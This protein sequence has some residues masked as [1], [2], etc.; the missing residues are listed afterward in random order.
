MRQPRLQSLI[1]AYSRTNRIYGKNKE[2]GSI[3]N[4]QYPKITEERVN[5]ALKLYGSGGKSSRAIVDTYKTAVEKLSIKVIEMIEALED[6]TN[7]QEL[8]GDSEAEE[9][10]ILSFKDANNQLG[11]VMQY[12]EYD[13]DDS[14]FG[15]DEHTWMKYVGA[16][17][18]LTYT[19]VDPPEYEPVTP[20]VGKTKLSGTQVI[21]ADHILALIGSKVKTDKGVQTV[22]KETLRIIYEEIQELSNM[23][24]DEQAKLL[25]E[26]V[27]TELVPGHLSSDL[28]FDDSFDNWKIEKLD[29]EVEKFS[30]EWGI[31]KLILIKSLN[32]F[33]MRKKDFIPYI[34]ELQ[35]N[36]NFSIAENQVAGNQLKHM[37]TLINK[38]IPEWFVEMKQKYKQIIRDKFK[39]K[40]IKNKN[41]LV[42]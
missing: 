11:L 2:F 36:I 30:E 34:D 29:K 39:L 40:S 19:I 21:D 16:Y 18:N 27:E 1:Q 6:P 4:F 15:I 25:K 26:F 31:D 12:Y 10:F 22:D 5:I 37:M 14:A 33:S 17:K 23:G 13:W 24:E 42:S 28:N 38:V 41:S 35:R 3:I 9:L 8:K 20:L 32:Q 7:W